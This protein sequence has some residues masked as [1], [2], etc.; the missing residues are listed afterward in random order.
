MKRKLTAVILAALL[1]LAA[2]SAGLI[3]C[4]VYRKVKNG[5]AQ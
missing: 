5:K 4:T 2:V 3:G 1:V